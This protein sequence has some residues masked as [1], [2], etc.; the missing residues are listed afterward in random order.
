MDIT[1][2]GTVIGITAI[3]YLLGMACKA[4]DKIPDKWIPVIAGFA[5]AL[6][7]IAGMYI[8]KDF[9]AS[10]PI[11][12]AAVGIASGLAATGVNQIVKQSSKK[13]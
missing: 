7:G 6:L 2:I 12:A 8:I 5:G 10:D 3:C 1:Q 11:N 4:C 9:P 13:V